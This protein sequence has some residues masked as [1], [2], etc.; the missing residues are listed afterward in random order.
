MKCFL[1]VD[2]STTEKSSN[3]NINWNIII[4]AVVSVAV[5]GMIIIFVLRVLLGRRRSQTSPENNDAPVNA[6]AVSDT[7]QPTNTTPTEDPA[8]Q[9]NYGNNENRFPEGHNS[10]LDKVG[11]DEDENDLRSLL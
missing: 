2:F 5:L 3:T 7:Q 4:V 1:I 9:I 6:P 8:G 11:D 10:A